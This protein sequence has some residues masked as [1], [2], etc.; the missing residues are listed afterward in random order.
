M[1][2]IA[3]FFIWYDVKNLFWVFILFSVFLFFVFSAKHWKQTTYLD[4][5]IYSL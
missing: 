1:N 5:T 2:N 3:M 4:I